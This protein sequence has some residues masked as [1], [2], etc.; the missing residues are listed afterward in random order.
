M[1]HAWLETIILFYV[2]IY[3]TFT[4][5]TFLQSHLKDCILSSSR[6]EL[7]LHELQAYPTLKVDFSKAFYFKEFVYILTTHQLFTIDSALILARTRHHTR[8]YK[9][10]KLLIE[11][12]RISICD[13]SC[14]VCKKVPVCKKISFLSLKHFQL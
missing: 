5:N 7:V 12:G 11:R 3:S 1:V 9:E 8:S 2:I 4:K 10:S 14:R 13:G 6:L